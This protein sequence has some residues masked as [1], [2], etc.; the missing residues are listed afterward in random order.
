MGMATQDSDLAQ[1]W[2]QA[3]EDY[4]KRTKRSLRLAKSHDINDIMQSTEGLSLEFKEFRH[5]RS[6]VEKVRTAFKNNMWLIEKVVNTVNV[7]GSSTSAFPPA[8]PAC[9]IFTAFGQVME[10][11]ATVSADYDKVMGF[12]DFTHRFFDRL[13]II[14]NRTP[15][16]QPFQRCVSR[17]FS[18]MLIICSVAQEYAA[19]KRFK[20]WF[21]SLI[22][23]SDEALAGAISNMAEAVNELAQAV[24]LST[25][26][27]VEVIDEVV[28][29]MNGNV[30]FLV[31]QT[32]VFDKRTAAIQS[33]TGRII[34]QN[35]E[36]ESKQDAMTE[37]QK[38]TMEKLNEQSQLLNDAVRS[39]GHI[40][41]G[42][43]FGAS[44]QTSLLKLDVV[45]LR[46]TRWGHAVGLANLNDVKSLKTADLAPEDKEQVQSL[47]EQIMELFEDAESASKRFKKR[48]GKTAAPALDPAQELD[49]VSASLHLKMQNLAIKRQGE[50]TLEQSE[51]TLYE[52][53]SFMRLIEDI[54]E[55]VDGLIDLFPE[56]QEEQRRMCASEVSELS[57]NDES[58]QLLKEA[59]AGRDKLLSDTVVK[60][61]HCTSTYTNSVVFSGPNSG[62]Q[63]GNNSGKIHDVRFSGR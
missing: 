45:R 15:Q 50:I 48:A 33:D 43:N 46:L 34:K 20:K 10:S 62:F 51:W 16:Q 56:S 30:E 49:N 40:Q 18:G 61:I 28:Q 5:D 2:Q 6:K 38:E 39:F 17:V 13:S 27:T 57:T 11:F 54:S 23:G 8:M 55:L 37:M 31:S 14:E 32:R 53:K 60:A 44:F 35:D 24:G 58:L 12:F 1:L 4:E 41:L 22:D 63:V 59:A 19:R 9:L 3:V 42:G 52:E 29:N 36:L 26:R 7:V 47:L 25:L 21:S